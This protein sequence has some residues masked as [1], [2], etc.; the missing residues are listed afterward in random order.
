MKYKYFNKFGNKKVEL[1]GVKFHSKKEGNRYLELK[2]LKLAKKIS[3]LELQ[4][5][6]I[7]H[8]PF[9]HNGKK[10]RAIKYIAD[11]QYIENGITVVEDVKGF[12]T[13]IYNLKKKMFL[14]RYG[15]EVKFI[16]T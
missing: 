8:D 5:E 15:N 13:P 2:Y 11:F 6:F 3:Y 12:K 7:I 10:I 9:E 14:K 4:P 1:D 16:E